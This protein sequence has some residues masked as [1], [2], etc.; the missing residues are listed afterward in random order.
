MGPFSTPYERA[1]INTD[2]AQQV[3]GGGTTVDIHYRQ[4]VDGFPANPDPV[5]KNDRRQLTAEIT[6]QN[7]PCILKIVEPRDV[8]IL[9]FGIVEVGDAIIYFLEKIDLQEPICEKP[10][11]VNTVYFVDSYGTK[12]NPVLEEV[13]ALK[14]HLAMIVNNEAMAEVVVCKLRK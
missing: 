13:G 14:R 11:A 6:K 12:W 1:L 3:M 10:A 4:Y 7:V 2:Y 5:Y 9:G 8:R